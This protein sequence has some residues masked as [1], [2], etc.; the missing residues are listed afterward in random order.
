MIEERYIPGAIGLRTLV[1]EGFLRRPIC[2]GEREK[3][4][5]GRNPRLFPSMSG[6][7]NQHCQ[8]TTCTVCLRVILCSDSLKIGFKLM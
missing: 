1:R 3:K 4:D 7:H 6:H 2:A 8:E 5:D